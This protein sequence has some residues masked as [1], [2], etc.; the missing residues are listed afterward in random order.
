M[1][2]FDTGVVLGCGTDTTYDPLAG[3]DPAVRELTQTRLFAERA[4]YVAQKMPL[5]LRWQTELLTINTLNQPAVLTLATMP[6]EA[7]RL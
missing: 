6:N 3:L 2:V 4:L 5:L 7:I 1:R